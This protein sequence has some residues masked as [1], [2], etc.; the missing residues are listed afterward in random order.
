M[1]RLT[2]TGMLVFVEPGTTGQVIAASLIALTWLSLYGA[3]KPFSDEDSDLASTVAQYMIFVQ[4]FFAVLIK[5][6]I[7]G[8]TVVSLLTML[9]IV[10]N[11]VPPAMLTA[12]VHAKARQLT[13][14]K[15]GDH[16]ADKQ[17]NSR[18][19]VAPINDLEEAT[20]TRDAEAA[21][22]VTPSAGV[23]TTHHANSTAVVPMN[24]RAHSSLPPLNAT[25]MK[26]TVG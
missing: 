24:A 4:L 15:P 1:R 7:V 2:L 10:M 8:D 20:Q 21:C 13:S 17:P 22:S 12:D 25:R 18:C 26:A 16:G 6:G 3:L 9:L 14:T 5:A 23:P 19:A 11:M